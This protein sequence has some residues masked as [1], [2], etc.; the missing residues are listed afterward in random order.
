M[1]KKV[2]IP[3]IIIIISIIALIIY[4]AQSSSEKALSLY[5]KVEQGNFEVAVTVTGELRSKNSTEIRAPSELRSRDL[6]S[7]S[8]KIQNLIPEGT[9]VDSGDWVATLDRTE[10]DN[11]LKD[12]LDDIEK[13][14]SQYIRTQLDT[15]IQLS[16]LR[17]DLINLEF[18]K[19]EMHIALEQSKFEPP[20]TIRQAQINLDK[21]QRA[22]EQALTNYDLKVEQA[23]ASMT[24]V[25]INQ[26]RARRRKAGIESL[27]ND[28]DIKAPA[29][30]MVIY[31]REWSGQ[32]RAVGSDIST[33]DL[34]VAELP[35]LSTMNS[36]TFVNE[37]DIS[38]V[39]TG[40]K[41]RIGVDAFPEKAYTGVVKEVANIGEQL[42]N[43]DAKVFEVII[44]VFEKDDI[45]RPAMTTSNLIVTRQFEDVMYIPLEAVHNND[46][47]SFVYKKSGVRQIVLLGS[48]NE[49][50]IIVEDGLRNG[51]E[52]YLSVPSD[53]ESFRFVGQEFIPEIIK[54]KEDME[55]AERER[56]ELQGQK[57]ERVPG[58]QGPA[59]QPQQRTIQ[60]EGN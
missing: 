12:V 48:S 13:I 49:N 50:A 29:P 14:E 11:E 1:K 2:L 23:R 15:T 33:W 25:T 55:R 35:D 45:L 16:Q 24:E 59:G 46:S 36:R 19:E 31:K 39:K 3:V 53:P 28:F 5:T 30:G 60:R 54:R 9:V 32:K 52:L 6:R 40:Q 41:V 21:S 51:E 10:V 17:D 22:Y 43:T 7:R 56:Q 4:S 18:H 27:L 57:P 47:V 38:K 26:E 20:A 8:I 37:I 34:V 42:P 58:R 44:E